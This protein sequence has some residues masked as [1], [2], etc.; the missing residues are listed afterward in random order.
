MTF[1]NEYVRVKNSVVVERYDV[2]RN[3]FTDFDYRKYT[4]SSFSSYYSPLPER[5]QTPFLT[6]RSA[7][8]TC[9]LPETDE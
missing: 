3:I 4:S 6:G 5:D 2:A 8:E 9:A 1:P 7:L